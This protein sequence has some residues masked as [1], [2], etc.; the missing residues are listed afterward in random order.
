VGYQVTDGNAFTNA[1]V[2][3]GERNGE[4]DSVS[5][6]V[7][8]SSALSC[9]NFLLKFGSNTKKIRYFYVIFML[10]PTT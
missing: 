1:G 9:D 8:A 7:S 6:P 2:Q 4:I 10:T 3:K 5:G